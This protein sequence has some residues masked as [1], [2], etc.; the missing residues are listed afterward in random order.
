[1]IAY[2]DSSVVL[3]VVLRQPQPLREWTALGASVTSALVR[4]ECRRNLDRLWLGGSLST[5]SL[6]T[7]TAEVE[8][9]LGR[10]HV[11]TLNERV[12]ALAALP[13]PNVLATLDALH[14]ATA[15][16]YRSQHKS[17]DVIFATHD[18]ALARAAEAFEFDV[19][20]T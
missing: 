10:A 4:V 15:M 19:I 6:T 20:G 11:I 9:I 16:L 13:L 18:I 12:L 1:M 2:L 3:R 17:G 7:K 8:A 14:L 5:D